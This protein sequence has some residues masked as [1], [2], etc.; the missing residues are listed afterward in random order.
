MNEQGRYQSIYKLSQR[1]RIRLGLE[2]A[3][4]GPLNVKIVYPVHVSA[5][6]MYYVTKMIAKSELAEY[7]V[8][9][10][11]LEVMNNG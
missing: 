9:H 5:S 8:E 7:L 1:E 6:A 2:K 11:D 10:P 3:P 4:K